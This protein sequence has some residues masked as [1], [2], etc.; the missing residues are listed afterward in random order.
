MRSGFRFLG[1]V[2]MAA[3]LA[4]PVSAEQPSSDTVLATV[5]GETI[6]LG[7]LIVAYATLPEQY[8][9]LSTDVLF[10]GI[11]EQLIQQTALAQTHGSDLPRQIEISL[12]NERR[13]L[14]AAN[15]IEQVMT[16]SVSD[17]LLQAAYDSKY[18]NSPDTLEFD[19]SHILVV[20]E[21]EALAIVEELNAGADFAEMAKNKST[22]PSG[23][24][25][26]ALGWF[27][28]GAMV[29]AFEAAVV[30]MEPGQ[31]SAPVQTQFGWHVIRLNDT[32]VKSAP[33]LDD[34]RDELALEIQKGAVEAHVDELVKQAQIDRAPTE[35]LDLEVMRDLGA[36]GD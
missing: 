11:L 24:R 23:P 1:A 18:A 6:T 21:D 13:S 9:Q 16:G 15:V 14:V 26:G 29:P 35:G 30:A 32:R 27:G 36:L 7:H 2:F 33:A 10:D 3:T 8:Q 19:A 4:A 25:G 20:T 12:E 22:G 34:V 17:E 5:N 31:I 28:K